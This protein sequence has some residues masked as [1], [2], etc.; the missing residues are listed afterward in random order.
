MIVK[1]DGCG[2]MGMLDGLKIPSRKKDDES[3]QK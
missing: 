2:G 3:N 1:V